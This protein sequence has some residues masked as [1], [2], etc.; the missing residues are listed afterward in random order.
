MSTLLPN[1]LTAIIVNL[2][3]LIYILEDKETTQILRCYCC[4]GYLPR[5]G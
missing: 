5:E 3:F 4:Q 1:E 2:R